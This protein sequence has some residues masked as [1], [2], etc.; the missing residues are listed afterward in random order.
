[1][2]TNKNEFTIPESAINVTHIEIKPKQIKM[3][4]SLAQNDK[5]IECEL[6]V[7]DDED[8]IAPTVLDC[9]PFDEFDI[10]MDN[11]ASNSIADIKIGQTFEVSVPLVNNPYKFWFHLKTQTPALDSMMQQIA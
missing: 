10:E 1:M 9:L 11:L 5:K 8:L 3:D 4:E 2:G 6:N 7:V